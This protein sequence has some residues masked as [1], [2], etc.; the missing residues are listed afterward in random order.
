MGNTSG[1]AFDVA[2]DSAGNP[3][4]TGY[5]GAGA[6]SGNTIFGLSI[7]KLGESPFVA[8]FN[9]TT[10]AAIWVNYA[11]AQGFYALS[12]IGRHIAVASD[13]SAYVAGHFYGQG[14]FGSTT[15]TPFQYAEG[16]VTFF[17][18]RISGAGQWLWATMGEAAPHA[19]SA[20]TAL[21]VDA[22]DNA[23]VQGYTGNNYFY[24]SGTDGRITIAG[25]TLTNTSF[26]AKANMSGAF[27]LV[28]PTRS[29]G[30]IVGFDTNGFT[31]WGGPTGLG[32]DGLIKFG[33][34]VAPALTTQ[35][36][37][38]TVHLGDNASLTATATGSPVYY[39]WRQ[40]GIGI[41]SQVESFSTN[42]T[43]QLY[44]PLAKLNW[45]ST[46]F[47][48]ADIGN[49]TL[50]LSNSS[51][52][53]TSVVA[54]VI[55]PA[56]VITGI[57]DANTNAITNAQPLDVVFIR[58]TNFA[59]AT[60]LSL[61]ALQIG[62]PL[63]ATFNPQLFY[64][65]YSVL[66]DTQIRVVMPV[67][68][69]ADS[70]TVTTP[71]GMAASPG[72]IQV[73]LPVFESAS[74]N[75]VGR[76]QYFS[77]WDT[78]NFAFQWFK[79]SVPLTNG[80]RINGATNAFLTVSN[81]ALGDAGGY[82]LVVSAGGRSVQSTNLLLTVL[83]QPPNL[84]ITSSS[85]TSGANVGDVA[86]FSVTA[87]GDTPVNYQWFKDGVP[88]AN[89]ARISG[90]TS[91]SL[92]ITSLQLT[93]AGTYFVVLTVAGG[94]IRSSDMRLQVSQTVQFLT[95]PRNQNLFV[96]S[97]VSFS[98][99]ASGSPPIGFQWSKDGINLTNNARISGANAGT[100]TISNLVNAD[101]GTYWVTV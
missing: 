65:S 23:W 43:F 58:G 101:A 88:L 72:T 39:Q 33:P 75:T 87:T 8:K 45:G 60:A 77:T 20:A 68:Y 81:L 95:L 44:L 67:Y 70:F 86:D 53:V 2:T 24:G 3:F 92:H 56:P 57:F 10:G 100:L 12:N 26:I 31:Y 16:D 78:P 48:P 79:D 40:D 15:L 32:V 93:D 98:A 18:A 69:L 63:Q 11:Q 76:N 62:V 99:T 29:A 37:G 34:A 59:G 28:R 7:P 64:G 71:G 19:I 47:S 38:Q 13:G 96:G 74:T 27:Q 82:Y 36:V 51:G 22:Q 42:G 1:W 91:A 41:G 97:N 50:V 66:S 55:A 83:P 84:T 90:A 14:V 17:L 9:G 52:M 21:A 54:S 94:S 80:T 4:I 25:Q 6:D 73:N 35:P 49:Y 89:T 85:F 30:S 46:T 5:L 61:G